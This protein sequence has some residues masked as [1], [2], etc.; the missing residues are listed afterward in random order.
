MTETL[1][2]AKSKIFITQPVTEKVCQPLA[3]IALNT[4]VRETDFIELMNRM[5]SRW[6]EDKSL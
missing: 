5:K 1:W 3:W 6:E 4:Q 2:S